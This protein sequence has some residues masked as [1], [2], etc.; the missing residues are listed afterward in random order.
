MLRGHAGPLLIA[1]GVGCACG[2]WPEIGFLASLARKADGR[3]QMGHTCTALAGRVG[4]LVPW[5]PARAR[6]AARA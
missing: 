6:G 1:C 4:L 2:G 3:I 5:G